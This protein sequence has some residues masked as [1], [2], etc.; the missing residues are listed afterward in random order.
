MA[1]YLLRHGG[2]EWNT[3]GRFQGQQDS[4]LTAQGRTQATA[5]GRRLATHL[6]MGEAGAVVPTLWASALGR[7]G[8]TAALVAAELGLAPETVRRDARLN[9][10]SLG[11]WNG[12]TDGEMMA[13]D[14][15]AWTAW[16]RTADPWIAAAPGGES[17][18]DMARRAQAWLDEH[19]PAVPQMAPHVVVG[20][21][22]FNRVLRG[23]YCGFGRD[24][25]MA[26]DSFSHDAILILEHGQETWLDG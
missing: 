8:H 22:A 4:P 11:S 15:A 9:E 14:E 1:I 25:I 3:V 20:H 24:F 13:R 21:G 19:V 18:A 10:V 12:L 16:R 5:M 2:T 26:L 23:L 7:S 17:R 6:A